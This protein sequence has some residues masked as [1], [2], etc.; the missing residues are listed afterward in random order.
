MNALAPAP[1]VAAGVRPPDIRSSR[2]T[3]GICRTFSVVAHKLPARPAAGVLLDAIAGFFDGTAI[4]SKRLRAARLAGLRMAR[5][6]NA[7]SGF[8]AGSRRERRTRAIRSPRRRIERP[9]SSARTLGY[10]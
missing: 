7:W 8:A 5:P 3:D 10:R 6:R 9:S 4:D 1:R 2:A